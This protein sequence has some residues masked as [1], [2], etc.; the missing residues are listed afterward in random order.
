MGN[1]ILFNPIS[2]T[3]LKRAV[4]I[5]TQEEYRSTIQRF[6]EHADIGFKT[7]IEKIDSHT[8]NKLKLEKNFLNLLFAHELQN[9]ELYVQHDI[10]DEQKNW[11]EHV[12]FELLKS[13]SSGSIKY[14]ILAC[15]LTFAIKKGQ[16]I[17]IDELDS[18][19]HA[20]LLLELIRIYNSKKINTLGSQ[21]IFT[22]HNT[23]LLDNKIIR[24]D[25]IHF[26]NKNEFGESFIERSHTSKSPVRKDIQLEKA[27]LKGGLGGVSKKIKGS[28]NT[29]FEIE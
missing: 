13:E 4:L 11:V 25:Q 3:N 21:M 10:Y 27:Y 6:L 17:L 28:G 14:L 1:L 15:Y 19:L 8:N 18:S 23:A 7:I 24:R 22:I 5:L 16:L 2:D 29:L 26:V 20:F 9:F 12:L